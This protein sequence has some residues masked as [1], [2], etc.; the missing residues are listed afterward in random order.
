M[1]APGQ[2]DAGLGGHSRKVWAVVMFCLWHAVTIEGSVGV[3]QPRV[4]VQASRS[5][6]DHVLTTRSAGT[7]QSAARS[8]PL[9]SQAS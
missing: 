8:Q 4:P 5:S 2:L 7:P 3:G 9:S 1:P 6:A